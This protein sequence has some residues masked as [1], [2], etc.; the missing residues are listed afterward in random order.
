MIPIPDI[1]RHYDNKNQPIVAEANETL[2]LTYFNLLRL[3]QGTCFEGRLERFESVYVPLSGSCDITVDGEAFKEVGRRE[4]VWSG[5]ADSVYAPSG[6]R[7]TVRA[8]SELEV[9]VAGGVCE[10]AHIP[11]RI[12]PEEVEVVE[13]GS[14]ATKSRRHIFH[15]LGQ[16]AEGRAGNLLVSE[17]YAE[18]GCWSG[19]PPHKHD[20]ERGD[21]ESHHEELYH[22]RFQPENGFGA[23]LVFCEDGSSQAFV[24]RHGDTFLLDRGY[25]P[26]VTSPGHEG[27][28][29]TVLVGKHRRSLS[30]HFKEEHRH[31]MDTIPGIQAMR[32]KFR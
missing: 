11:F 29:F 18:D 12:L 16:N 32:D 10:R 13:V 19:Y 15:I 30:Q 24:T 5:K 31:L 27:Y 26:T 21:E 4:D 17:L 22:Y 20:A 23:Q 8:L 7:V 1:I 25:H 14:S 3:K 6:G 28:I 2:G 9:A